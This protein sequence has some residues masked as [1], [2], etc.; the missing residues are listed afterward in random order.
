METRLP[1]VV[2]EWSHR[3]FAA[4]N[5]HDPDAI[6]ALCTDDV[7]W[8]DPA[9]P[10]TARGR[11][12]VR[13]FTSATFRAFP[14]FT[15]EEIEPPYLSRWDEVAL[16]PY[17]FRGTMTGPWEALGMAPTGRG[18]RVRGVDRW[19]FREGLLWRYDTY[20]DS[21]DMARQ[22]GFLPPVASRRER[23]LARL[24]HAQARA[25]RM[26]STQCPARRSVD[27]AVAR[28]IT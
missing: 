28:G 14:D 16:A 23:L 10:A 6:A 5:A 12:G 15:F 4:W 26:A 21:L 11:D 22:L 25:Q 9:L 18:F 7:E 8:H 20:Y 17:E 27:P 19:E 1:P 3:W 2:D 13:D 24:Q